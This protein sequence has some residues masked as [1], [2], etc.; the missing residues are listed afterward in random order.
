[1]DV[2]EKIERGQLEDVHVLAQRHVSIEGLALLR[3]ADRRGIP[4]E[5]EYL[6][7]PSLARLPAS[8]QCPN[9]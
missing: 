2:Q 7:C 4:T 1:M 6:F 3:L 9:P 8:F 5:R